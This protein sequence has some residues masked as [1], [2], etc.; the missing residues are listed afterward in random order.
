[1][2]YDEPWKGDCKALC[3]IPGRVR[4]S[5]Q[6]PKIKSVFDVIERKTKNKKQKTK[7]KL[8]PGFE[9]GPDLV[10]I[11]RVA[12]NV[13]RVRL[14]VGEIFFGVPVFDDFFK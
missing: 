7:K 6:N 1:M 5:G 10:H 14:P 11:L 3:R 9:L 8:V 2:K 13:H 12:Q 4:K